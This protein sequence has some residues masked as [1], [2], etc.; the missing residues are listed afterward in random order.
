MLPTPTL[1]ESTEPHLT[2]VGSPKRALTDRQREVLAAGREKRSLRLAERDSA[3][4]T[5]RLGQFEWLLKIFHDGRGAL[6]PSSKKVKVPGKKKAPKPFIV[7]IDLAV[8]GI[9]VRKLFY[10]AFARGLVKDGYDPEDCLQ[11]VYKG[12]LTRNSG[13]CPFDSRKSSFGH[14]VHIV[15]RCVLANYIRKEKRK[16]QFESTESSLGGG[17]SETAFSIEGCSD[18][19]GTSIEPDAVLSLSRS[20]GHDGPVERALQLLVEG[21]SRREVVSR[22]SVDSK[23]LDGVLQSAR[24]ALTA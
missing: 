13:T 22:L 21:Y 19:R 2:L 11:E 1:V 23:W 9:E 15:T 16:L 5:E 10:A 20:L 17:A 7:G 3:I 24:A 8:R 6:K 14:Y 12:L 4:I 18:K